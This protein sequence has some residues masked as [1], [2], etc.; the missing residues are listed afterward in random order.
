[1]GMFSGLKSRSFIIV[2]VLALAVVAGCDRSRFR[3][4]PVQVETA[5][6]PVTCQLYTYTEVTWDEA[7]ARPEGMSEDEAHG[8]CRAEGARRLIR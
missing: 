4:D 1:M 8:V 6:G 5:K 2:P 7:I 3:S